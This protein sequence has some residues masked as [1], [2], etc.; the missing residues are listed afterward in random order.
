V[1]PGVDV[2]T[3][4]LV[5]VSLDVELVC[6]FLA[7]VRRE[8]DLVRRPLDLA[9]ILL[10]TAS[11]CP[12][13]ARSDARAH[14]CR[15]NEETRTD[16]LPRARGRRHGRA[17]FDLAPGHSGTLDPMGTRIGSSQDDGVAE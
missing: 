12:A 9:G 6:L 14:V 8:V 17:R 4:D 1:S 15:T 13:V 11:R 2:V 5:V 7:I 3:R 16:G 10:V